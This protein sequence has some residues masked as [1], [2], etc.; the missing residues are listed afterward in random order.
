VLRD[1]SQKFKTSPREVP[2]QGV[3][4]KAA[5]HWPPPESHCHGLWMFQIYWD[6]SKF[7]RFMSF[8]IAWMMHPQQPKNWSIFNTLPAAAKALLMRTSL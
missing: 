4:A 5:T 3:S 1:D 2:D 7:E 6:V 8:T